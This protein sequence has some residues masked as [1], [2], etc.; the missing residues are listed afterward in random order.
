[1]S[2]T[3]LLSK[4]Y[5][6]AASM[7]HY[8][9]PSG[10]SYYPSVSK[11]NTQTGL[12]STQSSRA[13]SPVPDTASQI[14]KGS[15]AKGLVPANDDRAIW[16]SFNLSMQFGNDYVDEN[17][18]VGEPGSFVMSVTG[19]SLQDKRIREAAAEAEREKLEKDSTRAT[20]TVATPA[21]ISKAPQPLKKDPGKG[22]APITP[23][24]FDPLS[25]KRRK[26]KATGSPV[27]PT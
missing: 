22:K 1:M 27:S 16:D 8:A 7:Q 23:V 18:L 25:K 10:H 21:A 5:D 2:V 12:R 6:T 3:N 15:T 24:M 11:S 19:R 17:P 26:S 13:N 14:S 9:P 4:F 20:S